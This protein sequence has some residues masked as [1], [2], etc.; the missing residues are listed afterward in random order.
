[1]FCVLHFLK[2]SFHCQSTMNANS[3]NVFMNGVIKD[4]EGFLLFITDYGISIGEVQG[5]GSGEG[6]LGSK[7]SPSDKC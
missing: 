4:G 3:Q 6:G 7:A 5:V 2:F 1:M